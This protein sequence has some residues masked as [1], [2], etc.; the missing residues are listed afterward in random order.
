MRPGEAQLRQTLA[1]LR[2]LP[3][4]PKPLTLTPSTP[5]EV[6]LAAEIKALREELERLHARLNWLLTVI[7]GAALANSLLTVLQ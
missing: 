5:Y 2:R 3:P 7:I 6:Q 1:R 4:E